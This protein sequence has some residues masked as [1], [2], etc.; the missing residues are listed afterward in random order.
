MSGYCNRPANFIY[1][2]VGCLIMTY[3]IYYHEE[4]IDHLCRCLDVYG[5]GTD[6]FSRTFWCKGRSQSYQ[7][8]FQVGSSGC[9]GISGWY[10][11]AVEPSFRFCHP[12]GSSVSCQGDPPF[13]YY[14]RDFRT[15][16]C[17]T[18]CECT[19]GLEICK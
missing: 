2:R 12:A 18:S 10:Y 7:Y 16:I 13:Q 15:R 8:G 6:C 11:I 5:Y 17:R 4:T 9:I 19:V 1:L 14:K 3:Q